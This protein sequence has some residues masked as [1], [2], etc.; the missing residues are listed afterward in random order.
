MSAKIKWGVIGSAGIARRRTI[1][2]GIVAA[3][4]AELAVV[5]DIDSDANQE[6]AT[7]FKAK[8]VGGIDELLAE[9]IQAVYIATP[10]VLHYEQVLACA[11]A[12]KNILCEKPLGMTIE[13]TEEMLSVCE[14][15]GVV[16]GTGFMMRFHSQHQEALAMLEDGK[17]G[18]PVLGRAQLSC[19]YPPMDGA[20]RQEPSTGGGWF[21]DGYGRSLYRSAGNVLW[22]N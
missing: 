5:Y 1:P 9:D 12:G 11:A 16:L 3:D 21:L 2:E 8:A 4:N 18:V 17:I 7:E 22:Q 13:E 14:K 20:W 10:A 19:W 15:A 6:V